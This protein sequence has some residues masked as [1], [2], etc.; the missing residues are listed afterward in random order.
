MQLVSNDANV[1][2]GIVEQILTLAKKQGADGAEVEASINQGFCVTARM[3]ELESVEHNRDKS[4]NITVYFDQKMGAS[5][6]SDFSPEAMEAAVK[7]ACNIAKFTGQ[8]EYAGLAKP[9]ELVGAWQ[10]PDLYHPWDITV[11]AAVDLALACEKIAF[12]EN[13]CIENSEGTV[14]STGNCWQAYGN[15]HGFIGSYPASRHEIS[16]CLVGR[17]GEE[18]QRGYSYTISTRPELLDAISK[19]AKDAVFRT[20]S[21]LGSRKLSTRR[22]PVVFLAEEARGLL[23]HFVAAIS[24]GNLYRK[25]SF[26]LD[27]LGE[28][29]FPDFIKID[30][31]PHL[32][33]LLGSSPFDDDGVGT[34]EN[35]FIDAGYLKSYALGV[36][37]A[38]KLGMHTTGNAGGVHNLFINTGKHHFAGLLKKMNKGFLVTELMGQGINLVTGDY[39]RGA[40]GFWVENGEIQYPV[41]EVTIAGNLREIYARIL[42]VGSDVDMRGNIK[43]GSILIEEMTIAGT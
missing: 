20:V 13:K 7:A 12:S 43:T 40:S 33:G 28:K 11:N 14:I 27:C 19:V 10:D 1:L 38:R 42:E 21:R 39:S 29:I 23:G 3:G 41:E 31:R 15:S 9:E 5:S 37:S 24:G 22:V 32:P 4:L 8:D 6:L 16:C 25:S 18:M 36:Y 17:L 30:E 26:L 34:R 35:V 2:S